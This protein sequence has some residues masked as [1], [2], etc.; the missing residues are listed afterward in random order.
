MTF[1]QREASK[2]IHLMNFGRREII[3]F[4]LYV[5]KLKN[6]I[7]FTTLNDYVVLNKRQNIE[8]EILMFETLPPASCL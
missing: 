3:K 7:Q 4:Y 5:F 6:I 2:I 1:N 8:D